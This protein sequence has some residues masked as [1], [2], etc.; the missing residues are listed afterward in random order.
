MINLARPLSLTRP[1]FDRHLANYIGS[2]ENRID[3]LR[4]FAAIAVV[5]GHSWHMSLGR[6]A[7]VPLQEWTLIGFHSLAVHVFFFLSGLLVTQ[8]ALRLSAKPVTYAK[9]RIMRIFPALIVNAM[10]VPLGLVLAGA[11]TGMGPGEMA[12]YAIR[13]ITLVS[14]QYEHP[15]AFADNPFPGAINGSVWSLRHEII[16]YGLLMAAGMFG[17]LGNPLRRMIFVSAVAAYILAGYLVA[18]YADGGALYL[19]AEG[20]HVMTSFL[21]G[22]LAHQYARHVPLHPLIA[23]PGL[24]LLAA[25]AASGSVDLS[26]NGIIWLTCAATLLIA[27]PA[28]AKIYPLPHDIS[29]GVYIYS[30]PIQQLVVF[31]ALTHFGIA[32]SPLGVFAATMVMLVPVAWASWVWIERPALSLVR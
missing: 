2:R 13:L 18:P 3:H 11:W 9:K 16:V 23:L 29:Y 28:S 6:E 4:L 20:R 12:R 17:A 31:L 22:V 21:L 30:W 24:A 26:E 15:G 1:L 10:V 7:R 19:V 14:V 27:Y 32:L 5:L 8:S 25:G